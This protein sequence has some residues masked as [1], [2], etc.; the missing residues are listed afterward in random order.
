MPLTPDELKTYHDDG[1]LFYDQPLFGADEIDAILAEV[2]KIMTGE[3]EVPPYL[4][5][6]ESHGSAANQKPS[7]ANPIR[8]LQGMTYVVPFFENLAKDPRIVD[9]VESILGPDIKLY[10]DEYFCKNPAR[11]GEP[12]KPY[13]WH[14]DATNYPFLLPPTNVTTC[15]IA[16][17]A[18]TRENG[19]MQFIPKSHRFG[20][21]PNQYRGQ[22]LKHPDLDEP[23]Y[24]P[25]EP[26]YVVFHDGLNF[27]SSDQNHSTKPRRAIAFHYMRSDT[28][29]TGI[30]NE[31]LRRIVQAG[32]MR[33]D[34][35]FMP[36][37][38][39]ERPNRA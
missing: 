18:A 26:G 7:E 1:Y 10:T 8:K 29:Y 23:V 37:R 28:L 38:G 3:T 17:D 13:N 35:R 27:H 19:C 21:V 39:R 32:D 33:E 30:E 12:F 16:L 25:R 24:A 5:Q 2:D 6:L 20:A 34:F 22:F 14:Q 31:D 11:N 15:W 4:V 36:I 9:L